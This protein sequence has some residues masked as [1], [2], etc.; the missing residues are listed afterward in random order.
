MLENQKKILKYFF[1][2]DHLSNLSG[3][4]PLSESFDGFSSVFDS[5]KGFSE[6]NDPRS[7]S[8][9]FSPGFISSKGR[10]LSPS[11][12]FGNATSGSDSRNGTGVI[13]LFVRKRGASGV[14]KSSIPEFWGVP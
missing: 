1:I 4:S 3:L 6:F 7:T 9:Y 8:E 11:F 5:F 10:L 14:L 12:N 2:V 13:L